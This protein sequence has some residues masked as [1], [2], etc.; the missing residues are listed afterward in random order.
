ML[1][2]LLFW[3]LVAD[4]Q[5]NQDSALLAVVVLALLLPVVAVVVDLLV[6]LEYLVMINSFL[7]LIALDLYHQHFVFYYKT[8]VYPFLFLLQILL[9]CD[10]TNHHDHHLQTKSSSLLGCCFSYKM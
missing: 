10:H 7:F 8:L 9:S 5:L 1:M 4:L 3:E 6:V 2:F